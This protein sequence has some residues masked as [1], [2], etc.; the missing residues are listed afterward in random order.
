M[1]SVTLN[2]LYVMLS[3]VEHIKY[4][5]LVED[6]YGA[7]HSHCGPQY[8][9]TSHCMIQLHY[10]LYITTLQPAGCWLLCSTVYCQLC[11]TVEHI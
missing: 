7:V 2:I 1:F 6:K 4:S 5:D 9:I 8:K 10:G 11:L 3:K